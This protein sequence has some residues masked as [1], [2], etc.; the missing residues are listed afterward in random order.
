MDFS[1]DEIKE[2]I[3][4]IESVSPVIAEIVDTVLKSYGPELGKIGNA[5]VE[6]GRQST[7]DTFNFYINNGFTR[8]EALMLVLNSKISLQ[9][10]MDGMNKGINSSNKS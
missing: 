3:E 4:L 9:S 1:M 6:W 2:V 5:M 8:T 10:M 7:V